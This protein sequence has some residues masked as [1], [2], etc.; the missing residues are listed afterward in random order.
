MISFGNPGIGS[1]T[2]TTAQLS[3]K[4]EKSSLT[5]LA[6]KQTYQI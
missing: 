5:K 1:H 4:T 3:T 2:K 6:L